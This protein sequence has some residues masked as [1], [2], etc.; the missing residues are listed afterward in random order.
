M[1]KFILPTAVAVLLSTAPA[2]AAPVKYTIEP[3][4]TQAVFTVNHLGFSYPMGIFRASAGHFVFDAE[5]PENSSVEATVQ[6]ASI[7]MG[8][9]AW[10]KHMKNADFFNVEKFPTMTFK[11]SKVSQSGEKTA[12]V[13]GDLT[14]LGVT[15]PVTLNVTFVGSGEHPYS[16]KP[17][18]GFTAIANIR[19]SD[20]GMTYGLPA[21][22]DDVEIT[23]NVEGNAEA[24][25]ATPATEPAKQ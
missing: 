16:K 14:I 15:K 25:P 19:R 3:D 7:D 10:D 4:H 6:T 22:G 9:E 18:V 2:Q 24:A 17:T 1:M 20:F 8:T 5:K 23:L 13:E 21:V 12:L 11:S